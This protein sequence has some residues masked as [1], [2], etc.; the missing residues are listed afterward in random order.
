LKVSFCVTNR[1]RLEHAKLTIPRNLEML[2]SYPE[3]EMVL[4]NY[5]SE[6]DLDG[7]VKEYLS[8]WIAD[9]KLL[10]GVTRAPTY[11]KI[12]HAKNCAHGMARG[13]VLVNLD[14]DNWL[15]QSY[16]DLVLD[17][18]NRHDNPIVKGWGRGYGG[19]L[20][21]RR[22][23]F[24][25]VGGY[26]ERMVTWGYE[27]LDLYDR[28]MLASYK[29]FRTGEV[30]RVESIKWEGHDEM[31]EHPREMR[32]WICPNLSWTPDLWDRNEVFH[33]E[34]IRKGVW[35]ANSANRIEWGKLPDLKIGLPV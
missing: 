14:S 3:T 25:F 22:N 6:E 27:D 20:A 29:F 7:W 21:V 31:I 28:I 33:R 5:G 4:L 26:D 35:N 9:G 23:V 1:N 13:D 8:D 17:S 18:F 2:R 24:E 15:S 12:A 30:P 16:I 32:Q 34:N 19:R 10:Y 11:F